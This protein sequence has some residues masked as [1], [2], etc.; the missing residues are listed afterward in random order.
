MASRTKNVFKNIYSGFVYNLIS[1]LGPFLVRTVLIYVLGVQY[2]GLGNLFT[3]LLNVLSLTEAG[4]GSALVYQMYKPIAEGDTKK[5]S[6]LYHFYRNCYKV[7]GIFTLLLGLLMIPFLH[8]FVKSDLPDG[9][10][11]HVLYLIYLF[12]TVISYFLFAYKNSLLIA[13]QRNDVNNKISAVISIFRYIIEIILLLR[14]SNYYI[15][16]FVLPVYTIAGN[17]IRSHYVDKMFPQYICEGEI[18]VEEVKSL[19]TQVGGLLFQKIGGIVLSNVDPIVISSFLGLTVLGKY[20]NYYYIVTALF[21]FFGMIT[22]SLVPSIG[23]TIFTKNK[24]ELMNDFRK[25]TFLYVMISCWFSI[26]Y[27]CMVQVFIELWLGTEYQLSRTITSLLAAYLYTHKMSDIT[28]TYREA[29]GLWWEG[30][31]I[32]LCAA[33]LNLIVN[34]ILVQII[35]LPGIIISTIISLIFVYFPG[36][37]YVLFSRFFQ[38]QKS[39]L[40]FLAQHI[41]YGVCA[42]ITAIVTSFCCSWISGSTWI[43]LLY[44]GLVCLILPIPLFCFLNCKSVSFKMAW[45]FGKDCLKRFRSGK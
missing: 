44:R 27:L 1:I 43:I 21:G 37:S 16:V 45:D 4:I 42:F 20:N 14:F 5:V 7:I 24:Q 9:V 17:V 31:W 36:G 34:I 3:S 6:A 23:N 2:V 22:S 26:C 28:W 33:G 10:N 25:F 18:G 15:Y 35:G 39:W 8:F 13:H 30:K 29:A 11:L 41:Y 38:D 32:P 12:N 40:P 19:K